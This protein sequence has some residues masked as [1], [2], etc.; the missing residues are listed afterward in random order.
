VIS[1]KPTENLRIFGH[2]LDI[3]APIDNHLKLSI[4][5]HCP[6]RVETFKRRKEQERWLS[7]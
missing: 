2:I 5:E 6:N 7:G 1:R 3:A 4:G